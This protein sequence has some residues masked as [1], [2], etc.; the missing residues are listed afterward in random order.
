[1]SGLVTDSATLSQRA[2]RRSLRNP[3][4]ALSAIVFPLL[5][6]TLFNI[7][8]RRVM[9]ARGFDYVQLLPSTVVVQAMMFAGMS[10]AYFM[11]DDRGNGM[12]DRFRSLPIHR[13]APLVARTVADLVRSVVSIVTVV[14]V[15]VAIGMRFSAGVP[16]AFGFVGV[17]LLFAA[18]C[19]LGMGLIGL[20]ASSPQGA[21]SLASIPYLPLLMLSSGF[22][23]VEDF[24]GWLQPF[25][26]W[27]PV[28]AAID[29]LRALAG[30]GDISVTVARS[31]AWSIGLSVVFALISIRTIRRAS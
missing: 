20:V 16:A 24:A 30:D 6:F 8:L 19:S 4:T 13:L 5:F 22:A 21:S 27:Q 14:V 31:V 26:R 3:A 7:V 10:A 17:A 29:A 9:Q 28:T 12:F 25:V 23:P 15:G 18:T 11:A 2:M 1:M